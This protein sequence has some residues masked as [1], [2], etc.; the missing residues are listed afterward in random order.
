MS[1]WVANWLNKSV[2]GQLGACAPVCVSQCLNVAC[3]SRSTTF[4]DDHEHLYRGN[5]RGARRLGHERPSR[6]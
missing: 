2:R 1:E 6:L 5:V 4:K 3:V